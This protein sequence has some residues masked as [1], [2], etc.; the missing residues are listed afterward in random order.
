MRRLVPKKSIN[1][2]HREDV[3]RIVQVC[4]SKG[5]FISP[6]DAQEAWEMFSSSMCAGWLI[7]PADD[8]DIFSEMML[9]CDEQL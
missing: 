2:Y 4:E 8:K 6:S 1:W 9:Y 5:Y 7:L 3:A